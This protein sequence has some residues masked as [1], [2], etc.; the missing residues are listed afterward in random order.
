MR[1]G[2]FLLLLIALT[3]V[4]CGGSDTIQI[5]G[6]V[7]LDGKP[8][9]EGQVTFVPDN[10]KGTE[11]QLAVGTISESGEF[12]LYVGAQEGVKAGH[13]KVAVNCKFQLDEGSS[14]SGDES[15]GGK[16]KKQR[17]PIPRKYFDISTSGLT[18]EVKEG[19]EEITLKLL[20]K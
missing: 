19:E 12:S 16:S 11:G 9:K 5:K 2:S 15:G 18:Q 14:E 13:Y 7:L 1:M 17:C 4:G 10:D 6:K 20:S 8:L 3:L